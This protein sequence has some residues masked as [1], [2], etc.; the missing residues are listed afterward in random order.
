MTTLTTFIVIKPRQVS[1][2][3]IK[4]SKVLQITPKSS[5]ETLYKRSPASPVIR[6]FS[7]P[8]LFR[9]CSPNEKTYLAINN[10][11]KKT[12]SFKISYFSIP[13]LQMAPKQSKSPE[14]QKKS[15]KLSP[16]P[17]KKR[18]SNLVPINLRKNLT[19]FKFTSKIVKPKYIKLDL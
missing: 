17:Q 18:S 19:K 10:H 6:K 14:I 3:I 11:L 12:D 13:P 4:M 8:I 2:I 7:R 9:D 15:F 16:N 5:I 1:K